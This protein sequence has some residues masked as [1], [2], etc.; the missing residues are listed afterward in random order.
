MAE[1][2]ANVGPEVWRMV[3]KGLMLQILDQHWKE[4]LHALDHL[5]QGIGLRAYGQRDPLNEYK[6]EAFDMFDALLSR[7]REGVTT[8]LSHIEVR[9]EDD[10]P[11]PIERP[12]QRMFESHPD[13]GTGASEVAMADGGEG[14]VQATTVVRRAAAAGARSQRSIDLGAHLAQRIVPLR[15]GPQVQALPRQGGIGTRGP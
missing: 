13:P 3:E 1:R 11:P 7:L 12:R 4:H 2:A 14:A 15:L 8:V 5:R 10:K 9:L 6:R